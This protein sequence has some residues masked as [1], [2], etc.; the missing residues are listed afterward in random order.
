MLRGVGMKRTTGFLCSLIV[1]ALTAVAQNHGSITGTVKDPAGG[2][3]ANAGVHVLCKDTGFERKTQTNSNGVFTILNIPAGDCLLEVQSPG[4]SRFQRQFKATGLSPVRINPELQIG[5]VAES[6]TV[7]ASPFP[8]STSASAYSRT[9]IPAKGIRLRSGKYNTEQ[10][11]HFVENEFLRT[12]SNPLSTFSADVDTASYSN[13][14]RFLRNGELPPP[15]SVRVEELINY[16]TYDY[17]A[18]DPNEPFSVTTGVATCPWN[19]QNKLVHIGI[20]SKTIETDN[21]PPASFTFLIDVSGSMQDEAKLPLAV[22]SLRLLVSQLRD[23][24]R[25]GIVVYAGASGVVLRPTQCSYKTQILE[26]LDKLSAGGSTHGSAGI[27]AAYQLARES[28]VQ[29]GNN[30]VILLTDGDFNVGVSSDGELVRLIESERNSGIFLTV[31]G[32]GM[33]NYKDSKMEKLADHGNGN[34]AYIDSLQEVRK[35][36]IE[37]MAGTLLTVAQDVKLQVEFNPAR[38]RSWRLIGYENRILR[39]E[40]FNDDKKDAGDTGAGMSVTA[41]YEIVPVSSSGESV[42]DEQLRYQQTGPLAPAAKNS[43]ELGFLKI[44]YKKPAAST[45]RLLSRPLIDSSQQF[46]TAPAEM[47]FAAAVAEFGLLLRR[48]K[49]AGR[50]TYEHAISVAE[51]AKGSDRGGY[52]TEFIEL[53]RL[54]KMLQQNQSGMQ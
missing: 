36:L 46:L 48:S 28:F 25:I 1:C 27:K 45:S 7:H 30:R 9:R 5:G 31:L 35:V 14:R 26:A 8:L 47:R 50:S 34:Y 38:V 22:R 41:L 18:P 49:F 13:T 24:D 16:F 37:Q 43:R 12:R 39:P 10:Y 52:R 15:D 3:I 32:F 2:V 23:Q 4:F 6:V 44:R 19:P 29:G 17:P 11:D 33:G 54:A 20:R 40:E 51:S 21:L 42:S 53:L